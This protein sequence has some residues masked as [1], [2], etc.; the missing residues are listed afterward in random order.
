Q[1]LPHEA[2]NDVKFLMLQKWPEYR[3]D[4]AFPAE[5]KAVELL[6]DAVK[7]V[8]TCRPEMNVP[9][10]RRPT[11]PSPPRRRRRLPPASPSSS[12]W[13]SC[14]RRHRHRPRRSGQRDKE[15]AAKGVVT[16][17]THV[18]RI[19]MPLAELVDLEKEKARIAKA[20]KKNQ[21]EL[22]KLN[23]KLKNPGFPA[24]AP[25]NVVKT[26]QERAE[27]LAALIAQLEQQA[28]SL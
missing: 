4:L 21:G 6:M 5:E 18:A 22:D 25:E 3:E 8:R 15:E 24:K 12:A 10:P 1:A 26:E 28:A 11:S 9:L 19:G 7:A 17:V 13:A 2:G 20:L 27:K 16:V 14:Q 23:N